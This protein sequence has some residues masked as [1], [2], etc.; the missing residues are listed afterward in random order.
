[1]SIK[2]IVLTLSLAASLWLPSYTVQAGDPVWLEG[3]TAE[4]HQITVY[5]SASCGC[6]KGWIDHLREHSFI[7]DDR[8]V[9]NLNAIKQ[10]HGVPP[11]G[12]SCHTAVID[13]K[14]IEGH[15]PAQDIKRLL[16]DPG[17]IR[18]LTVPGMPSGGPG[19]DDPGARRDD[20]KVYG[21]SESGEVSV[22]NEY[23][24]Y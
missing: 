15:V 7:V 12:A 19:M 21:L 11:Q 3:R 18:L 10:Q 24:D 16:A 13:G 2:P 5:R 4:S 1:M 14:V 20:F 9:D 6:C 22:V 17:D 8:T 23:R